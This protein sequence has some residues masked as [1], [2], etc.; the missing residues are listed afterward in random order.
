MVP[1]PPAD[2]PPSLPRRAD[3]A[4]GLIADTH[5]WLDPAIH[6]QFAG[7]AHI[8]HA[9]DVGDKAV[10]E[11]LARIAPVTA[12]RGNIDWGPLQDLPLTALVTVAG[13]RIA[14]L[15]IAGSPLKPNA[16]ARDVIARLR[17]DVLLVGHSH[18][19]VAGRVG[20]TLWIN[21]GAAGRQGF[22][23][24]RTVAILRVAADGERRLFEIDLGPRGGKGE[25]AV[26]AW[27]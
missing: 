13:L 1:D 17:P 3:T 2:S 20:G 11:A 7:V 19:A 23:E 9:G 6:E 24:R 27:V 15:H 21:P 26:P 10:L 5:G 22:H 16:Q 8:V 25:A 4:I 12:V 14:S 18:I